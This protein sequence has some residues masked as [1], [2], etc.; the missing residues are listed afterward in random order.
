LANQL[1]D[2]GGICP[3][4]RVSFELPLKILFSLPLLVVNEWRDYSKKGFY[5]NYGSSIL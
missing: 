3:R 4:M 1:G 5:R 2:K